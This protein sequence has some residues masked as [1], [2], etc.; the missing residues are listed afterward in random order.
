MT[1]NNFISYFEQLASKHH[2]L[3]HDKPVS[4]GDTVLRKSFFE[5]SDE[6][7]NTISNGASYPCM[8]L[9]DY[10][11]NLEYG[12]AVDDK[13]ICRFEIRQ[14]VADKNAFDAIRQAKSSCK[15]TAM[16]VVA[17]LHREMESNPFGSIQ[18]FD[19]NSVQYSF[20][21]PTAN[22][23][24]GCYVTFAIEDE[25]FNPYTLAL[26]EIFS[27]EPI[28]TIMQPEAINDLLTGNWNRQ[29]PAGKMVQY[30]IINSQNAGTIK[31]GKT[32]GGDELMP[33]I[34]LTPGTAQVLNLQAY[35]QTD[36]R[37]Y[38]TTAATIDYK[39]YII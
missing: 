13:M 27:D 8:V 1:H 4:E 10:R 19:L 14:K 36:G 29:I 7:A 34:D 38:F 31:V 26:D 11:G 17:F 30:A 24:Y 2:V 21:G 3:R 39:I 16:D 15:Q 9:L 18:G 5:A 12:S 35:F 37:I 25:A 33:Q 32:A 22:S 6:Q 23:E 28:I 20:I